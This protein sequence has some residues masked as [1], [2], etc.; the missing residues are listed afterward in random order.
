V[1]VEMLG[2]RIGHRDYAASQP[3]DVINHAEKVLLFKNSFFFTY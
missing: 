2:N 1:V 3:C